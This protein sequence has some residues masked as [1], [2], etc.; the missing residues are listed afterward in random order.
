[1]VDQSDLL[2]ADLESE[3]SGGTWLNPAGVD[4]RVWVF[5]RSEK[6]LI[7]AGHRKPRQTRWWTFTHRPTGVRIAGPEGFGPFSIQGSLPRLLFDSNGRLI[8]NQ[9]MLDKALAALADLVGQV[10]PAVFRILKVRRIELS[11]HFAGAP[12]EWVTFYAAL[13]HPKIEA[14][15]I[16]WGEQYETESICINPS[17]VSK[18]RRNETT[19]AFAPTAVTQ[20]GGHLRTRIYDK[21]AEMKLSGRLDPVIRVEFVVTGKLATGLLDSGS[22]RF[23]LLYRRYRELAGMYR[24]FS[25]VRDVYTKTMDFIIYQSITG[26][27]SPADFRKFLS[28]KSR[29]TPT[30]VPS[31]CSLAGPSVGSRARDHH[32][33]AHRGATAGITGCSMPT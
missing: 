19:T 15:P 14:L 17:P 32:A 27:I 28:T 24:D 21:T 23:D 29:A 13:K 7:P 18:L 16:S 10:S 22:L 20:T 9:A 6:L 11:W 8:R 12:E 25:K 3:D 26:K 4:L 1:M 5:Q 2:I 30:E 33:S 31:T